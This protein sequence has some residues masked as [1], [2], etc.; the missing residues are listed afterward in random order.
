MAGINNVLYWLKA[1][2]QIDTPE[3]YNPNAKAMRLTIEEVSYVHRP[4]V[5]Y[6]FLTTLQVHAVQSHASKG[7]GYTHLWKK[8][9]TCETDLLA[10][11]ESIR[12]LGT[13][14]DFDSDVAATPWQVVGHMALRMLGFTRHEVNGIAYWYRGRPKVRHAAYPYHP[15]LA[16]HPCL[17]RDWI[18]CMNVPG[19]AGGACSDP[20]HLLPRHLARAQHLRAHGA[21]A[22]ARPQGRA[23]RGEASHQ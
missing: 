12:I 4:L 21:P 3:G 23:A 17:F 13:R 6:A 1:R 5:Y 22:G 7:S 8:A 11:E 20:A 18:A 9:L 16:S 2:F 19:P 10:G 15:L 14:Q